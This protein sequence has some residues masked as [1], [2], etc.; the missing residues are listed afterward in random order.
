MHDEH[1][2]AVE[3]QQ[4]VLAA[5]LDAGD[6]VIDQSARELL[7][8]V[9]TAHGTHAVDFHRFDLLADDLAVEVTSYD[10]HLR[11]LRHLPPRYGPPGRGRR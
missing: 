2:V 8:I 6:L 4:Q 1:V 9:V 11:Q 5:P 10:L 7:A 3:T